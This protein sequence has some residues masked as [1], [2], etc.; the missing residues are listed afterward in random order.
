MRRAAL[1]TN[2]EAYLRRCRASTR[3]CFNENSRLLEV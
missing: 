2:P 1:S 3:E